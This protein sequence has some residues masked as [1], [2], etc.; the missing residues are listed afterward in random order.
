MRYDKKSKLYALQLSEE[1][2]VKSY[3]RVARPQVLHAFRMT[4]EPNPSR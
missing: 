1:N 2:R 3:I 4:Q